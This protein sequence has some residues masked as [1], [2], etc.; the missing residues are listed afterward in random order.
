MSFVKLSECPK[1]TTNNFAGIGTRQINSDGIS[2]ITDL[3]KKTF[4]T[5]SES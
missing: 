1:I 3:Y 5:T 4:E 2:A